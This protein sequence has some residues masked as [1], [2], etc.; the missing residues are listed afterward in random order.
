MTGI[1]RFDYA[2]PPLNIT[3]S[4]LMW[5]ADDPLIGDLDALHHQQSQVAYHVIAEFIVCD[6]IARDIQA[7][8]LAPKPATIGERHRE[9][10]LNPFLRTL[11]AA[12]VLPL[13]L[14][15]KIESLRS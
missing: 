3:A 4:P 11:C 8:S 7:E 9:V 15:C 6:I 14:P 1:R 10:K 13:C 5:F 12:H 2:S